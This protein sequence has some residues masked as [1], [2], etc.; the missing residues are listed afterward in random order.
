M[1]TLTTSSPVLNILVIEDNPGDFFLIE[2]YIEESF[3]NSKVT[4]VV[5]YSEAYHLLSKQESIFDSILLDVTLPDNEGL[6][7]VSDILLLADKSPVLILTGYENLDFSIKSLS[8]GVSEYLLKDEINA[9][10]LHKSILYSIEREKYNKS[11]I[12]SE[13]KYSDLF[14]LSPIPMWVYEISSLKI[15]KVNP[16]A[17][18]HYGYTALEF[19]DM[20]ILNLLPDSELNKTTKL[21][22]EPSI[23]SAKTTRHKL[24][25]GKIIHVKIVQNFLKLEGRP[26]CIMLSNDITKLIETQDSLH[27]AYKNIIKIEE[28]EKNKFAAE[29]HDGLSQNLVAAQMIFSYLKTKLPILDDEPQSSLMN[30]A[31]QDALNECTQ[32]IREV[33]PKKIIENGF[34]SEI[35]AL[36]NKIKATGNIEVILFKQADI[37]NLF[38]YYGLMHIYRITQEL[39]NNSIKYASAHQLELNFTTHTNE[40]QL[41]YKDDGK[42]IT[43]K[44]L[45]AHSS[46]LSLKRRV[47]ILGATMEVKSTLN[48][49]VVFQINIPLRDKTN[50]QTT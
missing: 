49:G 25:N 16:A 44:T 12:E 35:E 50:V 29:L 10:L 47:Q 38:D 11:I 37:D 31:L 9:H 14:R 48:K 3:F 1:D 19:M 42:G 5:N 13:K 18:K 26:C 39:F 32:I 27:M 15:L 34:Y 30:K 6:K 41:L 45:N 8:L 17:I 22:S 36:V 2:E 23:D 28:N 21:Y 4:H 33:R 7:L 24:K 46:F 43:Q 40:I 20:S